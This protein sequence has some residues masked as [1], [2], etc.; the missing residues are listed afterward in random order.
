M[1]KG[2]DLTKSAGYIPG[3]HDHRWE[4]GPPRWM[5]LEDAEIAHQKGWTT[6]KPERPRGEN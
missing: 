2:Y 1:G 4:D 6:E 3:T 5:L